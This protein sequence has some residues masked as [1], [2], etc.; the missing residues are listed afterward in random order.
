V[1]IDVSWPHII[2]IIFV[3]GRMRLRYTPFVV[4][5]RSQLYTRICYLCESILVAELCSP[6][7]V[8]RA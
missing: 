1:R 7:I 4:F 8:G 5:P 2:E 6:R 3:R